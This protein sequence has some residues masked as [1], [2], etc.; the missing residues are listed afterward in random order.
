MIAQ[1]PSKAF[2]DSHLACLC[3]LAAEGTERFPSPRAPI[4][5]CHSHRSVESYPVQQKSEHEQNRHRAVD[6]ARRS[7]SLLRSEP[8]ALLLLVCQTSGIVHVAVSSLPQAWPTPETR[9]RLVFCPHRASV[10]ALCELASGFEESARA[11]TPAHRVEDSRAPGGSD[12]NL[13][14]TEKV[15]FPT[16]VS[17]DKNSSSLTASHHKI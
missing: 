4:F 6:H 12:R 16:D 9:R 2:D 11:E 15:I 1:G 17:S 8:F 13:C 10:L 7:R 3:A 5:A 14:N